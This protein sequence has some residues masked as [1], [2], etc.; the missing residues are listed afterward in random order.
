M[1]QARTKVLA[2]VAGVRAAL[3]HTGATGAA[4]MGSAFDQG[5]RVCRVCVRAEG[6]STA[7]ELDE[8]SL[9]SHVQ[10]VLVRKEECNDGNGRPT[11]RSSGTGRPRTRHCRRYS[12]RQ[13]SCRGFR[14]RL[15]RK[16]LLECKQRGV[17]T[18]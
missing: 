14:S 7:S 16:G 12:D 15:G 2:P 18:V 10:N 13:S 17:R 3:A 1:C 11:H 5:A 4:A 9:W 8:Q 6:A